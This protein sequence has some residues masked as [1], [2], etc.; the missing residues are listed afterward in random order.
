M[1]H[2]SKITS[3][4]FLIFVLLSCEYDLTKEN[5]VEIEPPSES[6]YF[7]LELVP[8]GDTIALFKKTNLSYNINT[9][10]YDVI[11][12]IMSFQGKTWEFNSNSATLTIDPTEFKPGIDTLTLALFLNSN[13]GSIA[14]F[15]GLEGYYIE[16]QWIVILDGRPAPKLFPTKRI[17]EDGFLVIEWPEC[18]LYNFVAYELSSNSSNR[19]INKAITD[20]TQNFYVDSLYVG[21]DFFISVSCRLQDDHTWGEPLN[22]YEAPPK[23][24]IEE[25]GFDSLRIS[26]KKSV[27]NAKYRLFWNYNTPL[28]FP[29]S[30]DTVC[31][32]PQIG[33]GNWADFQLCTKSQFEKKWT[34]IS[35]ACDITS[36]TVYY[37]GTRLIGANRPEFA[38]NFKD[39]V[40]YSNEYDNMKCFDFTSFS[41]I[42]SVDVHQLIYAGLY[43][44]PTNSSK[45]ATITMNE[46]YVFGSKNLINPA[47][48]NYKTWEWESYS[49]DHFLLTDNDRIALAGNNM[50]KLFD[51]N[52]KQIIVKLE[53]PD[54]PVASKWACIS[55]S[56]DARF[57]CM[58]TN[59]GIKIYNIE[60]G[61][62]VESFS[63]TR[64][65]RS[66][67]FNPQNPTQLYLTLNEQTGIEV[68][69]PSNFELLDKI[70]I[71]AEM[72]IRNIDPETN[73]ILIT[74]YEHLVVIDT[75]TH[76]TLL[77]IPC[78]EYK[79]WLFN[80]H[81]FTNSGYELN[82]TEKI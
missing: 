67:Y 80:N 81:I 64:N 8:A 54:Y 16:K 49:I 52:S 42:N 73:N 63:D 10:G 9:K 69:N 65:Y 46:I 76:E 58:A 45:V 21:G 38:Y 29:S 70:E 5:F 28:Y 50:Y 2:I 74:D 23:P 19:S 24:V 26:W 25:I 53:I 27:Y 34:D 51:V 40:L 43:S 35:Y 3:F 37:M 7:D 78:D 41:L 75:K 59:N 30:E 11:R 32:I 1:L 20:P 61:K 22:F 56:Q 39:K 82:I 13:S 79:S 36:S 48:F 44:C 12:S 60:T 14:N 31:V 33:L 77:K 68:R 72:V 66:A 71:P 15:A 18:K 55:T 62:I 47:I 6:Q 4:A 17:N 57:M